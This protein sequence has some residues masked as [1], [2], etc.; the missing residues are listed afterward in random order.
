MGVLDDILGSNATG[1]NRRGRLPSGTPVVAISPEL[2]GASGSVSA[3]GEKSSTVGNSSQTS[4]AGSS[5]QATT[6]GNNN[7][8]SVYMP[9]AVSSDIAGAPGAGEKVTVVERP[10]KVVSAGASAEASNKVESSTDG[11]VK[12]PR[13]YVELYEALNPY[14]PET[15]EEKAKREKRERREAGWAALGDGIAALSNL[16]FASRGAPNMYN[17]SQ[18]MTARTKERWERLRKE[19]EANSKAYFD[20][21]IHA[22]SMDDAR[23]RDDRNWRHTLERE[24]IADER[25]AKADERALKKEEREERKAEQAELM[26][27]AK[28]A[29]QMGKLTEQG[30]RNYI[31]EVQAGHAEELTVAKINSLNRKGTGGGGG[32]KTQ[33]KYP[34]F[35]KDGNVT[36][37]VWTKPEAQARSEYWPEEER[38]TE[39]TTTTTDMFGNPKSKSTKKSTSKTK[40]KKPGGGSEG[41]NGGKNNGKNKLSIHTK[42]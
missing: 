19:R 4:T 33:P 5:N 23:E 22:L 25:A 11:A 38:S 36:E 7:V 34:V 27:Q 37:Y 42:K 9:P 18:G 20:G 17:P 13:T 35:D 41:R 40:V 28:Y 12:R 29:L 39:S 21:Y 16:W 32:S 14:K 31:A 15:E 10:N 3:I 24:K 30:Y 8:K 2:A 26:W 1:I 6:A